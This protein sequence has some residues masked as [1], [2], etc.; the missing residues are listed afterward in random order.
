MRKIGAICIF[1]EHATE[2]AKFESVVSNMAIIN[3]SGERALSMMDKYYNKIRGN[4]EEKEKERQDL[5]QVV[6]HYRRENPD[7]LKASLAKK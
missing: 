7:L 4:S 2:Y 5:L 3:D 1:F 6:Q